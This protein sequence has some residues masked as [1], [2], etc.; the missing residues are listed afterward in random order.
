MP[1]QDDQVR[2]FENAARH[3]AGD[4]VFVLEVRIPAAATVA[5][6]RSVEATKVDAEQVVLETVRFDPVTRILDETHVRIGKDGIV[7]TPVRLRLAY[8]PEFDLMTRIAGLRLR[9]RWG[10]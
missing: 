7:L 1:S 9:E 8:P 3:L 6:Q 4:G 5:G 2:C 10:G